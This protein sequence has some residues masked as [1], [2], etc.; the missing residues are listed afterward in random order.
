MTTVTCSMWSAVHR[1]NNN[2]SWL[3]IEEKHWPLAFSCNSSLLL[4]FTTVEQPCRDVAVTCVEGA[5]VKNWSNQIELLN[6][7]QPFMCH[8]IV[9]VYNCRQLTDSIKGLG[10]GYWA[11]PK[12]S[13]GAMPLIVEIEYVPQ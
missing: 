3:K 9:F 5:T 8:H 1:K 7:F 10:D 6:H 13:L 11:K 4:L 2:G 12:T